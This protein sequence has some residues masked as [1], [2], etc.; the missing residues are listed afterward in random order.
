MRTRLSL[1]AV[2]ALLLTACGDLSSPPRA[3]VTSAGTLGTQSAG[4]A[5]AQ[6]VSSPDELDL[7]EGVAPLPSI[8]I[9]PDVFGTLAPQSAATAPGHESEGVFLRCRNEM[10]GAYSRFQTDPART[11]P[12]NFVEGTAFMPGVRATGTVFPYLYLGGQP[13]QGRAADAGI[14]AVQDG[15]WIPVIN[16]E[17]KQKNIARENGDDG[18]QYVYRL[19][20]NQSAR[21]RMSIPRDGALRLEISGSWLKFRVTPKGVVLVGESGLATREIV[22]EEATGWQ[23]A[24][25]DQVF[26]VMT[27][28]AFPGRGDFR[29]LSGSYAFRGS[30]WS[31]LSVG[32]LEGEGGKPWQRPL[33]PGMLW[34]SC[35]QPADIVTVSPDSALPNVRASIKLRERA[36]LGVPS[37]TTFELAAPVRQ[38]VRS[39]L[40]ITNRGVPESLVHYALTPLGREHTV[41]P[42]SGVLAVGEEYAARLDAVCG[43]QAGTQE[44]ATDLLYA[45]GETYDGSVPS[46]LPGAQRGDL[47]YRAQPVTVRLTCTDTP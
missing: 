45:V 28:V 29:L 36:A 5:S 12:V 9:D 25:G 7:S 37:G 19:S 42:E 6:D 3:A 22:H 35:A 14:Y 47:L 24:G 13:R 33:A 17:G 32:R 11:G 27:T 41:K 34:S 20:G 26:K 46:A 4:E 8:G 16:V 38:T 2:S 18:F 39:T 40:E 23:A 15:A 1:L 44:H 10:S 31:D 21:M 43:S 30:S